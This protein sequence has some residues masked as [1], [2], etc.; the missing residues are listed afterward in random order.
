M[1]Q[2]RPHDKNRVVSETRIKRTVWKINTTPLKEAHFAVFPEKL[3]ETPIKAC[4]PEN[5]TVLDPFAGAGTT[6]LMAKK[7]GRKYIGIEINPEYVK[8]A[9]KRLDGIL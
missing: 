2:S 3:V 7:L 5:G 8:I 6:L 9:N 4:C 1:S